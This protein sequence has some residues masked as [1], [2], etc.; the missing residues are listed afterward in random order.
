MSMVIL[1]L[2][3]IIFYFRYLLGIN[4]QY[5]PEMCEG[6]HDVTIKALFFDEVAGVSVFDKSN[7][8]N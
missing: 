7:T 1:I 2:V 4:I 5:E 6:C 8:I 3:W